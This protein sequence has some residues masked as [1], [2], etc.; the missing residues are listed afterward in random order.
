MVSWVFSGR[1]EGEGKSAYADVP[2]VVASWEDLVWRDLGRAEW[3]ET[4]AYV[5]V[6]I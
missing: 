3:A 2:G 5:D 6:A 4:K 1:R